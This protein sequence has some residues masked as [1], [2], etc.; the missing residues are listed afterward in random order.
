MYIT[1]DRTYR[2]DSCLDIDFYV[3]KVCYKGPKYMK[4]KVW[5]V[6]RNPKLGVITQDTKQYKLN[7]EDAKRWI[8]I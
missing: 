8:Q 1:A 2:V 4:I 3:T 7:Y 5:F 6:Y